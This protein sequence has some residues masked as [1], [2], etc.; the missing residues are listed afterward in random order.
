MP[1]AMTLSK[2]HIKTVLVLNKNWLPVSAITPADAFC[3]MVAGTA[4]GLHVSSADFR[5]L[6]WADWLTL[7]VGVSGGIGVKGGRVRL[8]TVIVLRNFHGLPMC[9]PSLGFRALWLRDGGRCQYSGRRL[10]A[11]EADIDHIL[12]RSRG[13][14]DSWENCVISDRKINRRK[15]ARTPEEAGLRL[16]RRPFQPRP[17]PV[18]HTIENTHNINDWKH[19]IMK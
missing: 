18:S 15:A 19:F 14:R 2:L 13:G 4:D 7:P 6:S 11:D 3:H 9:R 16:I 12:P 1:N 10:T 8:P 17:V 5:P